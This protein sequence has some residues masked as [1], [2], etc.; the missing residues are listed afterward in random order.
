[1][2]QLTDIEEIIY[3]LCV[4]NAN[5]YGEN[6]CF[7]YDETDYKMLGLTDNQIKGYLSQLV[8]K[9][10]V[11]VLDDCYFTHRLVMNSYYFNHQLVGTH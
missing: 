7:C 10:Y 3:T 6:G 8:G 5:S 4:E 1:M 2:K 9:G 11:K